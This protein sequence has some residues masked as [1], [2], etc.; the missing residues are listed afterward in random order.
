M[1]NTDMILWQASASPQTTDLW[2]L[3]DVRPQVDSKQDV[4]TNFVRLADNSVRFT[5]ERLLD[6]GDSQDYIVPLD[7]DILLCYAGNDQTSNFD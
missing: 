2:S 7:Q 1:K 5:S 6:T 4:T 3:G